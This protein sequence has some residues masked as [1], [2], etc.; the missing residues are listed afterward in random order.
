MMKI[1]SNG[2]IL[3][4]C[5]D[6]KTPVGLSFSAMKGLTKRL[7]S[8]GHS[9]LNCEHHLDVPVQ[10]S[11]GV[12]FYFYPVRG[13]EES[14]VISQLQ[15]MRLRPGSLAECTSLA[16]VEFSKLLSAIACIDPDD[17][18]QDLVPLVCLATTM[19]AELHKFHPVL[20]CRPDRE[21][22]V[23]GAICG[24]SL[25]LDGLIPVTDRQFKRWKP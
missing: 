10:D 5:L 7:A 9:N 13:Q 21:M 8:T 25:T 18:F 14:F 12:P 20:K 6:F 23:D 1:R 19:I 4:G 2:V 3:G 17:S 24:E 15:E 16:H 22:V 11:V